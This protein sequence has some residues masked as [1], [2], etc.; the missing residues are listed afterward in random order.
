[1]ATKEITD[2]SLSILESVE[3]DNSIESCQYIGYTPQSQ[4]NINNR[5]TP[6]QIDINASD[7][8]INVSKSFLV[9]KGQLVRNDDGAAYAADDEIA[10]INNAMM[11]LFT[12]ISFTLGGV[13][14]ERISSPGQITSMLGYL[15]LPDDYST[16]SGLKSCWSKDST[17]HATSVEFA[18][19]VAAPA[20]H[21]RPGRNGEYNQGFAAR[22]ALLMSANPRGSFSF[23]IPFDHI[24]GFGSYNKVIYNVKHSLILTRNSSDNQAIY[25]ANAVNDGKINL[26]E[27]TWKVPHIKPETVKLMEL[28]SIIESKKTIP[29]AFPA[30]TSDAIIVPQAQNFTWR[31]NVISGIEKP[32]WIIVGFQTDRN[33]TQEQN[34]AAF[35]HLSITSANVTLNSEKFPL[36]DFVTNFA[37]NDYSELYEKFDDFKKEYYGFNSLVGGTQVNYAAFK[38]LFP[39]IVFDVRRQNEKIKSGVID[40]QLKFTFGNAA[41]ADTTAY[42]LIISDRLYKLI[43]N[44]ENLT[45][46][47]S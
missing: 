25:H 44:G 45:L 33:Q 20:A 47:T 16:S 5:S 36:Y 2:E 8:Y 27:I 41:P 40:M 28:R 46:V 1:M 15:S 3:Y 32:R 29:V 10:L 38:S 31:I 34:P 19:S 35:D 4:A 26:T 12:E 24:F 42:A 17:N 23:I 39:I 18:E 43:S 21:Y 30:R 11:Y 7:N 9:I 14:M 6:I 37:R 13:V 22:K